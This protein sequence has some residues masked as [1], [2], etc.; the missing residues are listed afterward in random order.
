MAT[1]G[2]RPYQE[3]IEMLFGCFVCEADLTNKAI[4]FSWHDKDGR[5]R[6]EYACSWACLKNVEDPDDGNDSST[7]TAAS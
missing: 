1:R 2:Q 3:Y 5:L 6:I 4:Q 7:N